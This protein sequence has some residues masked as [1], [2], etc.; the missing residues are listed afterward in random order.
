[1]AID[2]L[3]RVTGSFVG[4]RRVGVVEVVVVVD[5]SL[6]VTCCPE[7]ACDL[8]LKMDLGVF[9]S[10]SVGLLEGGVWGGLTFAIDLQ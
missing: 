10:V 4:D 3:S 9:V 2:F 8:V 7:A 6:K 5:C 1:M